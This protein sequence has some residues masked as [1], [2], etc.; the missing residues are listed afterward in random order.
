VKEAQEAREA[1][2][3]KEAYEAKLH[4]KVEEILQVAK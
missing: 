4:L 3:A 2:E 1:Q